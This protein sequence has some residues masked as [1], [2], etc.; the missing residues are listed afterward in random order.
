MDLLR[1]YKTAKHRLKN[2]ETPSQLRFTS[3]QRQQ[4]YTKFE[5]RRCLKSN[6]G[7]FELSFARLL[8]FQRPFTSSA[9]LFCTVSETV[10]TSLF[11]GSGL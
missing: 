10:A 9:V 6:I 7:R 11:C 4:C 5:I 2:S 8:K 1:L 3:A